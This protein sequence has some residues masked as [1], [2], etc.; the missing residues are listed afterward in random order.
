MADIYVALADIVNPPP[1]GKLFRELEAAF[2]QV[3]AWTR[4]LGADF[5]HD[6]VLHAPGVLVHTSNPAPDPDEAAII[7][8]VQGHDGSSDPQR[9]GLVVPA[10]ATPGDLPAQPPET[11]GEVTLAYVVGPPAAG[12]YVYTG[13]AWNGPQ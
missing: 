4:H 13:G 9:F 11:P 8:F 3:D 12:L 10:V 5:I 1:T 2:A 7:A 6:G